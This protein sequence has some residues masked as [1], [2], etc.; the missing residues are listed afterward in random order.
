MGIFEHGMTLQH[1]REFGRE[2]QVFVLQYWPVIGHWFL[3]K[4]RLWMWTRGTAQSTNCLL[5]KHEDL[6]LDPKET[7]LKTNKQQLGIGA[8]VCPPHVGRWVPGAH[9]PDRRAIGWASGPAKDPI[10]QKEGGEKSR[11]IP[12]VT[13]GIHNHMYTLVSA[14]VHDASIPPL[15]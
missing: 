8:C 7:H 13:S 15:P 9:L 3:Q 2:C 6:S 10:S 4:K 1:Y 11:K 14:Q 12:N 5:A